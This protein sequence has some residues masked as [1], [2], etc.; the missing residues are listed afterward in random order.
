MV[1]IEITPEG[2]AADAA[3]LKAE[4]GIEIAGNSGTISKKGVVAQWTYDGKTLQVSIVHKPFIF[5]VESCEHRIKEWF[6]S[7]V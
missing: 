2:F 5:S 1:S 4:D 6:G 7:P 3:R